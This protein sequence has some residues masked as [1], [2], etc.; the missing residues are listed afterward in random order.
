MTTERAMIL[1]YPFSSSLKSQRGLTLLEMLVVVFILSAVALMTVSFTGNADD[2]FRFEETRRRLDQI[3]GGVVGRPDQTVNGGPVIGGFVADVGRMPNSLKELIENP[4]GP[5]A[6]PAWGLDNATG[7]W[8]GWR[9]PYLSVMTE[10]KSGLKAFRDGWGNIGT[11]D[12]PNYGW[13]VTV[14]PAAGTLTVVSLG[15]DGASSGADYAADYPPAG[16]APLAGRDD[17]QVNLKG[18]SVSVKFFNPGD[19][20]GPLLPAT[21]ADLRARFYYPVNGA[22]TS[23]DSLAA[24]LSPVADGSSAMV[25]FQFDPATDRWVPWGVRATGVV[26]AAGANFPDPDPNQKHPVTLVPRSQLIPV[27]I[28]WKLE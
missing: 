27:A 2:Q 13:S 22:V 5:G 25:T 26:T 21:A 20:T 6:L 24:T 16:S 19:G 11:P 23:T 28:D 8:S 15:S 1:S 14:D 9:G 3:R 12:P 10:Q 4:P 17:H 18:W 7:L